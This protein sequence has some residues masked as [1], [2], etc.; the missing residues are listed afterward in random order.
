MA[1][2]SFEHRNDII[3]I[4]YTYKY[5]SSVPKCWYK[6]LKKSKLN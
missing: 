3:A 1:K 4:S 6:L 2:V 5:V